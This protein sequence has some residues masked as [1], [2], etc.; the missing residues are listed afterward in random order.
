MKKILALFTAAALGAALTLTAYAA[1]F[2][3]IDGHWGKEAIEISAS[4][5]LINGDGDG[6]FRPDDCITR[7]EAVKIISCCFDQNIDMNNTGGMTHWVAPYYNYALD[8]YLEPDTEN[9]VVS[10]TSALHA[11]EITDENADYPI[12]RWEIAYLIWHAANNFIEATQNIDLSYNDKDE[13]TEHLPQNVLSDVACA[14]H[15]QFG[16]F[17]GDENNNFNGM[18]NTTRAEAA[19]L[20]ARALGYNPN[21]QPSSETDNT[22]PAEPSF[23]ETDNTAPAEHSFAV[24]TMESGETFKIELMPEYAPETVANFTELVKSGFYNGLTFHR[25][26]DGF[27]AQGGDPNGTGTGG[28]DKKIHGEFAANG[29]TKNTLSHTRGV[30]SMARSTDYNSASSQFFICYD[31]ASFLDGMYAAFGK[32]VEGMETVDGFLETER[33]GSEGATPTTPIVIRTIELED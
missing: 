7:A 1:S 5:G 27:M 12:A 17:K 23:S 18:S 16:L 21:K 2:S 24:V 25:V 22:T 19:T 14:A 3:D 13:L 10:D 26:I 31:D 4:A 15:P 28:S 32:V 30:I 9:V 20:L 29:F 6:T 8:N 33:T 11:G